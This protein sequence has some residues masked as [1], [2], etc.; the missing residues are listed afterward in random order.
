[1]SDE[2]KKDEGLQIDL[3]LLLRGAGKVL[4]RFWWL[5]AILVVVFSVLTMLI[6]NAVYT[7]AYKS[8]CSFTVK[9][10]NNSSTGEINTLYG[11]YYDKDLAEQLDKT[12]TYILTSDLL[13]DEIREQL[14]YSVAAGNIEATCITG[15]NLFVL[16]TFGETPQASEDLLH[17][18]L[19]VY[20][21]AARYVVGELQVEMVE[22]PV[23]GTTPDSTL[24]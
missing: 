22:Q 8:Y 19:S 18:V 10:I 12:F 23:I 21:D 2:A 16:S 4:Q 14:G 1:M 15:S 17:A 7:P 20:A 5:F 3:N 6:W 11:F 24:R 13:N 9:V